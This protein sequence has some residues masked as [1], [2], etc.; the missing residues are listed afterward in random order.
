MQR[1]THLAADCARAVNVGA[2]VHALVRGLGVEEGGDLVGGIADEGRLDGGILRYE[3]RWPR[4]C[5]ANA[6]GEAEAY[7]VTKEPSSS[8]DLHIAPRPPSWASGIPAIWWTIAG[9]TVCEQGRREQH[10]FDADE[11]CAKTHPVEIGRVVDLDLA[12]GAIALAERVC[13]GVYTRV[14]IGRGWVR[15]PN[16]AE[17]GLPFGDVQGE[18]PRG[19]GQKGITSSSGKLLPGHGGASAK[20]HG[21]GGFGGGSSDEGGGEGRTKEHLASFLVG[22]RFSSTP[23]FFVPKLYPTKKKSKTASMR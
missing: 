9:G 20:A 11:H 6:P 23:Q 2:E 14:S 16:E 21:G 18:C 5:Q 8:M 19:S 3:K 15:D 10:C 4:I 22:D 7:L 12:G 13:G 17:I 1:E